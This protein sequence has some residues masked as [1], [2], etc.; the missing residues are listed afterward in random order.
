MGLRISRESTIH[1]SDVKHAENPSRLRVV[2]KDSK[3][4]AA[5]DAKEIKCASTIALKKVERFLQQA[6]LVSS[7]SD[8]CKTLIELT[9]G[10]KALKEYLRGDESEDSID[11]VVIVSALLALPRRTCRSHCG[12]LI[13]AENCCACGTCEHGRGFKNEELGIC[14]G[15]NGNGNEA[16]CTPCASSDVVSRY[17][18]LISTL[19][20]SQSHNTVEGEHCSLC[21]LEDAA[22][23]ASKYVDEFSTTAVSLSSRIA[24]VVENALRAANEPA[25]RL[26][27][28]SASNENVAALGSIYMSQFFHSEQYLKW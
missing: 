15:S 23:I 10:R 2:K 26:A 21:F 12:N 22:G 20:G 11:F 24:T 9:D 19:E 5:L 13:S 7:K 18:D 8:A 25:V 1:A 17:F 6:Y 4:K 28:A 3:S 27:L 16:E 14:D